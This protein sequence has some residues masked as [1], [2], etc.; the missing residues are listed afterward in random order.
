ML[1]AMW[2]FVALRVRARKG[3]DRVC[4]EWPILL[5]DSDG[6]WSRL[7]GL[8]GV[9]GEK[10]ADDKERGDVLGGWVGFDFLGR[11]D[12]YRLRRNNGSCRRC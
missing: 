12:G 7:D 9:A 5:I 2:R 8:V 1:R 11:R 3:G 4:R 10:A 6:G